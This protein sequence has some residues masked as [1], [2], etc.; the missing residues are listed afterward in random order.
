MVTIEEKNKAIF[1][2]AYVNWRCLS[3]GSARVCVRML[4]HHPH[5]SYSEAS[6]EQMS[7]IEMPLSDPPLCFSCCPL[8]GDLLV[9]CNN[10][11]VLFCLKQLVVSQDLTILDFERSLILHIPNVTPA[12]VAFCAGYVAITAELE[13]LILKLEPSEK[14]ADST[15]QRRYESTGPEEVANDSKCGVQDL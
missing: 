4:G 3:A 1:L 10:K 12:E 11:L 5:A 15:G 9:G 8:K 6:K 13:V 2:R 7:I 14:A